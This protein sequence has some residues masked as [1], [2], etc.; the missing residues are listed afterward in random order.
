LESKSKKWTVF[1]FLHA[2][3]LSPLEAVGSRQGLPVQP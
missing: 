3:N 2:C 1:G